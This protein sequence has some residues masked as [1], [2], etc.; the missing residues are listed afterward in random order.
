MLFLYFNVNIVKTHQDA[1][2]PAKQSLDS[3]GY[4]LC[5]IEGKT[6]DPNGRHLFNTGLKMEIPK[7][8][9]GRILPRS[10]LAINHGIDTAAGVIDSDYRGEI[11]VLLCNNSPFVYTVG[12]GDRIAQL[13]FA[14]C[15]NNVI[16]DENHDGLSMTDR[17]T[18][19]FGSTGK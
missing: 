11:K 10:G 17:G 15:Y 9:Y 6:I 2:I 14:K 19:G 18:G 5:C 3:A 1:Q 16:F 13:V 4:D 7:G 12:K 8:Y